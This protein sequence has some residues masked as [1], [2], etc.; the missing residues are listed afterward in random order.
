M[1]CDNLRVQSA[2]YSTS[3]N[4]P[5]TER[6]ARTLLPAAL[7]YVPFGFGSRPSSSSEKILHLQHLLT[8]V[9]KGKN[10]RATRQKFK[11]K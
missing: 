2:L 9:P 8:Q 1:P 4:S 5:V 3:K 11:A 10:S 7:A 6:L